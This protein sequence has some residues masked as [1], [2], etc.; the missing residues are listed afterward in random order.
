LEIPTHH[1]A[2]AEGI[3]PYEYGKENDYWALIKKGFWKNKN[4][5]GNSHVTYYY[6]RGYDKYASINSEARYVSQA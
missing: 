2:A 3:S 6:T 5:V 1:L 4:H